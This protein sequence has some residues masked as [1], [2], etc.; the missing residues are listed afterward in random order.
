MATAP[1]DSGTWSLEGRTCLVTGATSGIGTETALALARQGAHVV[2]SGRSAEKAEATRSDIVRK[3][4]N[5]NVDVLL[6]DLSSLA[7]VRKLAD[8]FLA[9]Y[10]ALHVLVNNAGVVHTERRVTVDGFEATF[11]VNHLAYF[12]LTNLLLDRLRQS[13]P[14]RIVNVASDAHAFGSMDWDDLQSERAFGGPLPFVSGMRVYGR[15]KLANILFNTELA[16][17]LEGS[18][19][20]ANCLHPGMVR[21]GL[22]QN[23]GGIA[24]TVA[25]LL[26]LPLALSPARGAETSIYLASSPE[27]EGVSGRYFAK[28]RE[29]RLSRDARDTDA[30]RRL[31]D[32]SAELVGLGNA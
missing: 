13:A 32:I 30:A 4:G 9:G 21:T 2:I 7:E 5:P 23:N 19:V 26:M 31:W 15:S 22:G 12:L 8:S 25:G 29:A 11:A 16:R 10:P 18:G 27:V 24:A 28:K 6:A 3:S 14:A 20:T 17:R 1:R